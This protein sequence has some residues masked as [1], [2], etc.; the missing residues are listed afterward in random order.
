MSN[1]IQQPAQDEQE[2]LRRANELDQDAL[3]FIFD[4]YY[5]PI[6]RYIYRHLRHAETAEDL[7]ADV[8]R[9]LL[10][11]LNTKSGPN[12]FLKAWLYKVAQNLIV[13]E[14][15][16]NKY[17]QTDV[18]DDEHPDDTQYVGQQ[19]EQVWTHRAV[20]QAMRHLTGK[21][22]SVLYLK[23]LQGLSND[24]VAY[25]LDMTIGTVKALQHRGLHA[26]RRYLYQSDQ[27]ELKE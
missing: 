6:Y 22:Q 25:T 20:R 19:V 5:E 15:R 27:F 2:L 8:F 24:E 17:R 18:I 12:R 21:Q 23:F 14:A 7:T 10:E 11:K 3:A 9:V 13:D 26:L 16:R 4:S 1:K